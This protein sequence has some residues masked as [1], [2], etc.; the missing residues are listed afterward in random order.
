MEFTDQQDQYPSAVVSC[1]T[2]IWHVREYVLDKDQHLCLQGN[3]T[4]MKTAWHSSARTPESNI[5]WSIENP[6]PA[7]LAKFE[8]GSD[9][10]FP[11]SRFPVIVL[12][13]R[14]KAK[15]PEGGNTS[16][17]TSVLHCLVLCIVGCPMWEYKLKINLLTGFRDAIQGMP[18]KHT[19]SFMTETTAQPSYEKLQ[20]QIA[21]LQQQLATLQ[22][23]LPLP[24]LPTNDQQPPPSPAPAA[25]PL[26]SV[27]SVSPKV[28]KSSL[29]DTPPPSH[30]QGCPT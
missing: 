1:G 29:F 27:T 22:S 23:F 17:A 7:G 8:C 2:N 12:N 11:S 28:S 24:P 25:E 10:E 14:D 9:V 21:M 30:Y 19:R 5:Y 20:Q 15:L 18:S 16:P 4:I 26:H 3:V 13:L 6:Y